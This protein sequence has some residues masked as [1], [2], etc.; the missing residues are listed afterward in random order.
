MCAIVD[1]NAA[2][3]VF[4]F[5]QGP[6][7]RPEA[8]RRFFDWAFEPG[9]RMRA[10]SRKRRPRLVVGGN[11]LTELR[12]TLGPERIRK[13]REAQLAGTVV[14]ADPKKVESRA[15]EV[16]KNEAMQSDDPHVLGLA[17]ETGARLLYTNG[18]L[19]QRDFKDPALVRPRGKVYSVYS[20]AVHRHFTD[21]HEGLLKRRNLCGR[22]GC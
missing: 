20:T 10:S 19:L 15:R 8:G 9:N 17:L 16:A 7:P 6:D 13:I 21:V 11:L 2:N 4:W 22:Q 14:V 1:A 18:L 5:G 3:E 12:R